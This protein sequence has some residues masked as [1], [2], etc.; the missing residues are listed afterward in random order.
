MTP[1]DRSLLKTLK[2]F[3]DIK[4][5]EKLKFD[6]GMDENV[7][8]GENTSMIFSKSYFLRG[9]LTSL[10]FVLRISTALEEEEKTDSDRFL[11]ECIQDPSLRDKLA[12]LGRTFKNRKQ[13]SLS[14][15]S[16]FAHPYLCPESLY[17]SFRTFDAPGKKSLKN[18]VGKGENAGHQHFLLFPQCFLPY[19][20]KI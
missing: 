9:I 4:L 7:G 14:F 15:M 16:T 11:E 6:L 17:H 20:R 18:I 5:T 8:K 12:I 19:A 1:Q 13:V 3:V 10:F 2:Q